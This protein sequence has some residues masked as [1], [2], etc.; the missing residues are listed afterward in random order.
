MTLPAVFMEQHY[1]VRVVKALG[2]VTS[3]AEAP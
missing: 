2:E 3:Q 1:T